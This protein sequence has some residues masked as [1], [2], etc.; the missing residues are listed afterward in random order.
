[1]A[2]KHSL[3]YSDFAGLVDWKF[4][5]FVF[6]IKYDIVLALGKI[7]RAGFTQHPDTMSRFRKRF[8]EYIT[9]GILPKVQLR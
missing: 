3:N 9:H 5:E 2:E 1:M 8:D 7:R 4:L 6:S